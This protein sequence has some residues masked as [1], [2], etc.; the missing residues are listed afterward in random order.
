MNTVRIAP[1]SVL[2]MVTSAPGSAPPLESRTMPDTCEP[3]TACANAAVVPAVLDNTA[4]TT[5]NRT[6]KVFTAASAKTN[7]THLSNQDS[8]DDQTVQ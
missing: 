3:A 7:P 6:F 4:P 8:T 5:T 1:V 2:V